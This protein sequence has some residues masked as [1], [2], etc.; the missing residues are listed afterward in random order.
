MYLFDPQR[1][2]AI[3]SGVEERTSAWLARHSSE[4]RYSALERRWRDIGAM[5]ELAR[6]IEDHRLVRF[7]EQH[8]TALWCLL[9]ED[10]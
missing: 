4:Q 9:D 3:C 8:K 7:L 6:R 5:L 1:L 10:G 2:E